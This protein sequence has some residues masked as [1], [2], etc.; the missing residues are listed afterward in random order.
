LTFGRIE[1]FSLEVGKKRREER[2][3]ERKK[4]FGIEKLRRMVN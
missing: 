4:N 1:K 3:E 2:R